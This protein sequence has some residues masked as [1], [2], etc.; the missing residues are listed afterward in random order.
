MG[1][2]ILISERKKQENAKQGKNWKSSMA[3][4]QQQNEESVMQH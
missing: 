3:M 1:L 2:W 4:S